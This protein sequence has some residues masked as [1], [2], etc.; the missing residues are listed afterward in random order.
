MTNPQIILAADVTTN[1]HHANVARGRTEARILELIL[2]I[3]AVRKDSADY[4]SAHHL[5]GLCKL[6]RQSAAFPTLSDTLTTLYD[7]FADG[8]LPSRIWTTLQVL[9][10][11]YVAGTVLAAILTILAIN[12]RIG[13]DFL[14]TMT[15]MF[16]PLPAH[17]IAAACVDLVRARRFQPCLRAY[18]FSALGGRAQHACGLSWR[19]A[20]AA[21]GR[22]QLWID[23]LILCNADPCSR[24]VSV[25]LDRPEDRLGASRGVH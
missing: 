25:D 24:C 5:A 2:G 13:T 12:T 4:C 23:G 16:N 17:L 7:R 1:R 8:T 10:T 21:H 14:E 22:R 9:I 6:S 3:S 18:P 20:N 11:G 19:I 15:A